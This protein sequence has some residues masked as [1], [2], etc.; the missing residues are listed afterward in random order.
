MTVLKNSTVRRLNQIPQSN[1]VWEGDRRSLPKNHNQ[2]DGNLIRL[3]DHI[4]EDKPQCI[5]WVDGS[6]GVVRSMDV[7]EPNM[8]QEAIV[9]ALLQAIE[10]PQSPSKP[11]RPQRIL[12]RDRSLQFYLRGILQSLNICVDHIDHLPMIDEI[13]SNL[14]QHTQITPPTVPQAQA[15]A[16]Y[17][18]A[19]LFW[20]S[21]PWRYMW[22]HQVL[23]IHINRWDIETLYA[24]IMGHLGMERG[25]IFYQSQESLVR[26][27]QLIAEDESE[28]L[29]ETF[30]R[31]DCLFT[32]FESNDALSDSEIR[33]LHNQG[34][35]IDSDNIH[36]IFG[37]LHPLEGG[38]PFLYE[39]EAIGL[40]VAMQ[41]LN[42]FIA[43][44]QSELEV[45]EYGVIKNSYKIKPPSL[46]TTTK[47]P[48]KNSA[49]NS[50]K[51][52]VAVETLPDLELE[53]QRIANQG[54]ET[55][56]R[57]DLLPD[58]AVIKL[59]GI[60]WEGAQVWRE[61]A[62]AHNCHLAPRVFPHQGDAFSVL[63]LQTSRP[64][65]IKLIAEVKALGNIRGICFNPAETMGCH[66]ELGLLV[67]GNEELHLFGEFNNNDSLAQDQDLAQD[68]A[69]DYDM[70]K[71]WLQRCQNTR[72]ICAVVIAMGLS[73][74][75]KGKPNPNHILAYYE[76]PLINSAD[77]GLGV[78]TNSVDLDDSVDPDDA[79]LNPDS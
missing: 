49:K 77:L 51:F 71:R 34:W 76:V 15:E 65:A 26:F 17:H 46:E 41:S 35:L 74:A 40:T 72:G 28:D 56:I 68:L 22:D 61:Y 5:L 37:I 70:R 67:M 42:L 3:A 21:S 29:E 62:P 20:R 10:R 78:L 66:S 43:Q 54:E 6:M 47:I 19:D 59:L 2:D 38:R 33:T 69:Q 30:L 14:I 24:V 32:L 50:A 7:V 11:S 64:K 75:T 73:G 12:V 9:R 79:D 48:A 52:E 58:N 57:Q 63:L 13:F 44:H 25:V 53:I 23:A 60:S 27:R 16:L 1:A 18:Q 36:P 4:H 55:M 31:Q 8:G 39:E 45:G